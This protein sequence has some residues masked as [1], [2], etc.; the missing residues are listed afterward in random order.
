MAFRRQLL[1]CAVLTIL[2]LSL[3]PV[4]A[5]AAPRWLGAEPHQPAA[6]NLAPDVT[7]YGD[8][9]A[10]VW[11]GQDNHVYAAERPRGGPWG[12]A[13]DLDPTGSANAQPPKIA[14][15]RDGELVAM[16]VGNG[17]VQAARRAPGGSSWS[18]PQTVSTSCCIAL[19]DL[20]V[21]AEGTF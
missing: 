2:L 20:V 9:N 13:D 16:W 4:A 11:I 15:H 3:G 10:A 6:A 17:D 7:A 18:A 14:A 12:P 21:G 8:T 5:L 1:K 19:E